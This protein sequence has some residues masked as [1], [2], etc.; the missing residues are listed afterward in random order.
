VKRIISFNQ[1][2]SNSQEEVLSEL[3]LNY[4]KVLRTHPD[5]EI[6]RHIRLS[7]SPEIKDVKLLVA[8]ALF[9]QRSIIFNT[10]LELTEEQKSKIII[11]I[12][13]IITNA[14]IKT[15]AF[16]AGLAESNQKRVHSLMYSFMKNTVNKVAEDISKLADIDATIFKSKE[17]ARTLFSYH[18]KVIHQNDVDM[19]E[20]LKIPLP[21]YTANESSVLNNLS[22]T[23]DILF[24]KPQ[25]NVLNDHTARLWEKF[26]NDPSNYSMSHYMCPNGELIRLPTFK[27]PNLN[28]TEVCDDDAQDINPMVK[29]FENGMLNFLRLTM[30]QPIETHKVAI[31]EAP[32]KFAKLLPKL[33][34]YF[35]NKNPEKYLY[36][37]ET[38]PQYEDVNLPIRYKKMSLT[39]KES[40]VAAIKNEIFNK[41]KFEE[42]EPIKENQETK[43]PEQ[44]EIEKINKQ[45]QIKLLTQAIAKLQLPKALQHVDGKIRVQR[46]A[47]LISRACRTKTFIDYPERTQQIVNALPPYYVADTRCEDG[48]DADVLP[49][50]TAVIKTYKDPLGGITPPIFGDDLKPNLQK[51][52][53]TLQFELKLFQKLRQ[54][55]QGLGID[56]ARSVK[57]L[58]E[59]LDSTQS[60]RTF[61]NQVFDELV[62]LLD[63]S[64]RDLDNY[65]QEHRAECG[66]IP[67][68]TQAKDIIDIDWESI[69]A[70]EKISLLIST[71]T[72]SQIEKFTS[73]NSI[74]KLNDVA[75]FC[76]EANKA[77]KKKNSE[78]FFPKEFQKR[79]TEKKPDYFKEKGLETKSLIDSNWTD[80][81]TELTDEMDLVFI[82]NRTDSSY[83]RENDKEIKGPATDKVTLECNVVAIA[84][85]D[86]C[87][88]RNAISKCIGPNTPIKLFDPLI[89]K[90]IPRSGPLLEIAPKDSKYTLADGFAQQLI[91]YEEDTLAATN[92]FNQQNETMNTAYK[93]TA[94]HLIENSEFTEQEI[95]LM[96]Q[97]PPIIDTIQRINGRLKLSGI[98]TDDYKLLRD[99]L[100]GIEILENQ[101]KETKEKILSSSL[102]KEIKILTKK[103]KLTQ[104]EKDTLLTTISENELEK[105]LNLSNLTL[106]SETEVPTTLRNK[107][108]CNNIKAYHL[109]FL[110]WYNEQV[111][112]L[113]ITEI[114][115]QKL[116][117]LVSLDKI[118]VSGKTNTRFLE[119]NILTTRL[120]LNNIGVTLTNS[121]EEIKQFETL[122]KLETK[123]QL[124]LEKMGENEAIS[125]DLYYATMENRLTEENLEELEHYLTQGD[126]ES[127]SKYRSLMIENKTLESIFNAN[128]SFNKILY[129]QKV[130]T[131]NKTHKSG[132]L[133][134]E[135]FSKH[136]LF[137]QNILKVKEALL[138]NI[139][140]LKAHTEWTTEDTD[141]YF[142]VTLSQTFN[143]FKKAAENTRKEV[144]EIRLKHYFKTFVERIK[145]AKNKSNDQL[146]TKENSDRKTALFINPDL[147]SSGYPP[148]LFRIFGHIGD[149]SETRQLQFKLNEENKSTTKNPTI[150]FKYN[151]TGEQT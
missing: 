84:K 37:V 76:R 128:I 5:I 63:V 31:E 137:L 87:S 147:L 107:F 116:E 146:V 72:T 83:I 108:K 40:V 117:Q 66:L 140:W 35:I 122:A 15:H 42:L 123:I 7:E 2:P 141:R 24:E 13:E 30:I 16:L 125:D 148:Y 85:R 50:N 98:G 68:T 106:T 57:S 11:D 93:N 139:H 99:N 34:P 92:L 127:L 4:G 143:Q 60:S 110:I 112:P 144:K 10:K 132:E 3:C 124:I 120:K 90:Y 74:G 8:T 91:E 53:E 121:P 64:A 101:S 77:I 44:I 75:S 62:N 61:S 70:E 126:I 28:I 103:N 18:I 49:A 22:D 71:F 32:N 111:T 113:D 14:Y 69:N 142:P 102:S 38:L 33:M 67:F 130:S 94:K 82:Q 59:Q 56:I 41:P 100:M 89:H 21:K 88:L 51:T 46:L 136:L 65:L 19:Y 119:E 1:N 73:T 23:L 95:E 58:Q 48:T 52:P 81:P 97:S 115:L 80:L 150:G 138:N 86:N 39:D 54:R 114:P 36:L 96:V 145:I 118:S 79:F 6:S 78:E 149:G 27:P 129:L 20:S 17:T 25:F 45:K 26:A 151:Q 105:L 43:K 12:S 104:N 131:Y 133:E 135:E 47:H 9:K 55:A 109:D 134:K 29:E